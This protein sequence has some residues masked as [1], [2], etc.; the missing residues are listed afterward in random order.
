[1]M[2]KDR[3]DR[4]VKRASLNESGDPAYFAAQILRRQYAAL[5]RLVRIQLQPRRHS[6]TIYN[7]AIDDV[8]SAMDRWKQKGER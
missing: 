6:T 4:V 1:M 3:F 2:Q 8:L 5:R 7:G